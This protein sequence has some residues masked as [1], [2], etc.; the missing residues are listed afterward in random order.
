MTCDFNCI[1]R[2]LARIIDVHGQHSML[3][4]C[5]SLPNSV[6]RSLD[7][8]RLIIFTIDLIDYMMLLYLLGVILNMLFAQSSIPKLIT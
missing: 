3:S 1:L 5:S 4:H 7:T 6:L 2:D 8:M